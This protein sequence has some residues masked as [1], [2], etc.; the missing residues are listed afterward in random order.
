MCALERHR[1]GVRRDVVRQYEEQRLAPAH[2]V[3]RY[4]EHEVGILAI[5]VLEEAAGLLHRDGESPLAKVLRCA[6]LMQLSERTP[7]G[8]GPYLGGL[9]S[10]Q[11]GAPGTSPS[12]VRWAPA[13]ASNLAGVLGFPNRRAREWLRAISCSRDPLH[14]CPLNEKS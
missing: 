13:E 5:H 6:N 1:V 4:R 3:A 14:P 9:T 11:P 10:W 2:E 8:N 7:V 12:S